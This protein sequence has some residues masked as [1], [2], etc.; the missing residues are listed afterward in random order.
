VHKK[1]QRAVG[2]VIT[3]LL[4]ALFIPMIIASMS[5][6]I[7]SSVNKN[8]MPEVL[9]YIPMCVE[10]DCPLAEIS[11]GDLVIC[12]PAE[13][14]DITKGFVIAFYEDDNSPVLKEVVEIAQEDGEVVYITASE[15]ARSDTLTDVNLNDVLGVYI[16]DFHHMGGILNYLRRA[17]GLLT[18]ILIPVGWIAVCYLY[19]LVSGNLESIKRDGLDDK[20]N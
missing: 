14:E 6:I 15:N 7:E 13:Q 16:C 20:I 8:D 1:I 11:S 10:S 18:C 12:K 3:I 2:I 19:R 4:T 9:G 17:E 5:L